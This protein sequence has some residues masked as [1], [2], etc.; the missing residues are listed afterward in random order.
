M[1]EHLAHRMRLNRDFMQRFDARLAVIKARLI[2]CGVDWEN[3]SDIKYIHV[4]ELK[5]R[6]GAHRFAVIASQLPEN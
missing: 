5:M 1:K 4:N 6:N 3:D 2:Q